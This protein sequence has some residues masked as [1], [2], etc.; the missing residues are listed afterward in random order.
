MYIHVHTQSRCSCTWSFGSL[1]STVNMF[2][3]MYVYGRKYTKRKTVHVHVCSRM[4]KN[5]KTRQMHTPKAVSEFFQKTEL[6]RTGFEHVTACILGRCSTNYQGSSAGT[7]TCAYF[8]NH[9]Q[10]LVHVTVSNSE[11]PCPCSCTCIYSV[12]PRPFWRI[13]PISLTYGRNRFSSAESAFSACI[14]SDQLSQ[15]YDDHT[16]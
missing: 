16:N 13:G 8:L 7:C 12:L 1:F 6:P 15:H 3:H 10:L 11:I 14:E 9:L 5:D 2:T 4:I